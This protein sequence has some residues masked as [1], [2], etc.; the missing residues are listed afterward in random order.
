VNGEKID[1]RKSA[2]ATASIANISKASK[3]PVS[4]EV[5]RQNSGKIV[6]P[7][8]AQPV[9]GSTTA[10]GFKIT[11]SY[12]TDY[13][14]LEYQIKEVGGNYGSWTAYSATD[15]I[16]GLAPNT[17][18]LVQVRYAGNNTYAESSPSAATTVT[19]LKAAQTA[20]LTPNDAVV[21]TQIYPNPFENELHIK[22]TEGY[23][24][25]IFDSSGS[26]IRTPEVIASNET[27]DLTYLQAGTYLFRLDKDGKTKTIWGV[28]K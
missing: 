25:R 20:I 21:D 22:G 16:T 23:T 12:L 11:N 15:G 10:T 7:T 18:Y 27:I 6:L 26:L 19:T 14:V 1:D 3:Y 17:S 28:K 2:V 8:P 4:V 13:G 9:A 24:L 5:I